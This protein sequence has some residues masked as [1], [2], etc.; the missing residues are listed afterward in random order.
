MEGK[1]NPEHA[2]LSMVTDLYPLLKQAPATA[3]SVTI[4]DRSDNEY[5]VEGKEVC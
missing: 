4:L 5:A 1:G 2:L 3:A